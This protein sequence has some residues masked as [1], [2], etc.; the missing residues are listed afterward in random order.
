MNFGEAIASGFRNYVTF[1]GRAVR[2][3]Y[4][5]WVLFALIL[6]I[7]TGI[8]DRAVFP[9]SE[10]AAGPI[11]TIANVIILLPSLA[12]GVRRLHDIDRSGWWYLIVFTIIGIIPLIYWACQPGT[13]G[14]NRFGPPQAP[15]G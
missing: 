4:W 14:P 2:S 8:L 1:S 9:D 6:G 13:P 3:E 12:I 15:T 5:Y 7:V 10:T 11:N